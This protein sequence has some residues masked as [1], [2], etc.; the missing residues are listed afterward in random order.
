M[1]PI[2][3]RFRPIPPSTRLLAL[4]VALA[5]AAFGQSWESLDVGSV[6]AAGSSTDDRGM[7]TIRGSGTDIWGTADG[8]HFL[9]RPYSGDLA[10]AVRITSTGSGHAWAKVGLMMRQDLTPGARAVLAY[11]TAGG[12]VGLQARNAAGASSAVVRDTTATG[13]YWLMLDR[14]GDT[15]RAYRSADGDNWTKIGEITVAMTGPIRVGLAVS[16][17]DNTA[18]QVA[19]AD[20]FSLVEAA[21]PAN[22]VVADANGWAGGDIGAVG[23]AGT[24]TLSSDASTITLRAGGGD[25]WGSADALRL[26]YRQRPGDGMVAA[27]VASLANTDVWAKAGVMIRS[28]FDSTSPNAAMVLTPGGNCGFQARTAPGAATTYTA[29]PRVSIGH[30]VGVTRA[31]DVFTGFVSPDGVNWTQVGSARIAMAADVFFGVAASAHSTSGVQTTA[32]FDHVS[33]PADALPPPP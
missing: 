1:N 21:P 9:A 18:L 14:V 2:R 27:R 23:S 15:F 7:I 12:H 8:C 16:S 3:L 13:P 24:S 11:A 22:A 6:G 20:N 30:W 29:G 5:S 26:H 32:V 10:L 25:M 28:T 31:G 17:H 33:S 19:T 4:F